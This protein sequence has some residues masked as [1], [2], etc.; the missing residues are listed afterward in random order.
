MANIQLPEGYSIR[1]SAPADLLALRDI[2]LKA[3]SRFAGLGL[4]DH[5][6]DS[7]MD[8][9]RLSSLINDEL[10][11]VACF[12][13][14]PVGFAATSFLGGS[15]EYLLEEL[16][17]VPEHG[18]NKLGG[19]LISAAE[20]FADQKSL[21]RIILSTFSGVPWNAPFYSK[22]GF[23]IMPPEDYSPEIKQLR[24]HESELGL[25]MAQ[26]VIM[27]KQLIPSVYPTV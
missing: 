12:E 26:R 13:D 1:R 5:M 15:K 8:P 4:I 10:V 18:G 2:E 27:E 24:Q 7:A 22:L 20:E 6:L 14:T 9:E 11:W 25:P 21:R 17:V 23:E 16:D 3:A 19:G